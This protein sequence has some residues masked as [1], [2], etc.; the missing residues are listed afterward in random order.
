MNTQTVELKRKA[1]PRKSERA[2][3]NV[4]T[5]RAPEDSHMPP[6]IMI[7]HAS[8][9]EKIAT[10]WYD[11][12]RSI[13]PTSELR[14][15]S[16]PRNP[17]FDGYSAFAEQIHDWIKE[18]EYCLTVQTPSSKHR[19]WLIW[20]AGLARSLNKEIFVVLYGVKP[21]RLENP[22]D[23]EPHYCGLE[24]S[25][26]QRIVRRI[27]TDSGV[28]Y[29][30]EDLATAFAKYDQVLRENSYS[31]ESGHV[32]YEKRILLELTHEQGQRLQATGVIPAT[33][34]VRAVS[35]SL[36]I[37]GYDCAVTEITWAE[38]ISHLTEDDACRSW[39]GSAL[40]W[41]KL[42]G[43]ILKKAL[44][45]QLTSANPEGLPLYYWQPDARGG[46]I[47]YRPSIAQQDKDGGIITFT[48]DFNEI[49]PELTARA[50]GDLGIVSHHL[51][52][53]RM[54]HWGVLKNNRFEDFFHGNLAGD[55]MLAKSTE[56]LDALFNI[57]IEFQNRGLARSQIYDAFP[58]EFR[59]FF[60]ALI[61][62]YRDILAQ[63]EP[64]K[65]P[66]ADQVHVLYPK[67]L[68]INNTLFK[69]YLKRALEL[70]SDD[71]EDEKVESPKFPRV[72][73]LNASLL[74]P[75]YV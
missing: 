27:A 12:L 34:T 3:R 75:T 29:H 21:G 53:C 31:F 64:E 5:S 59:E 44:D 7:S 42:L 14:Y 2:L 66:T 45:R 10:A 51:D 72:V 22:L 36:E 38:L 61:D 25:D 18:T 33:V 24:K 55:R 11:V 41:T 56:F 28:T 52:F 49:P 8:T 32:Q 4:E 35:C 9:D 74:S 67:L 73:R 47:S 37:F 68:S 20:E 63:L 69:L 39:P 30:E 70:L 65:H 15:S 13:F 54:I 40:A 23:S 17:P 57:R 50:P 62:H 19:P 1:E 48:I 71:F 46:G 16:D 60:T 58:V 26:V 6:R 43:R